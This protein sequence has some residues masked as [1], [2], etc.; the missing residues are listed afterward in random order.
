M[1]E[2]NYYTAQRTMSTNIYR[3]KN[4]FKKYRLQV[5]EYEL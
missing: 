5:S 4:K 3:S 1:I 2:R